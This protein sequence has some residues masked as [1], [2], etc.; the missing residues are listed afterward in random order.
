MSDEATIEGLQAELGRV[1]E[2]KRTAVEEAKTLRSSMADH[3]ANA[4]AAIAA[5]K[6]AEKALETATKR[7][8]GLDALGE[9]HAGFQ[10]RIADLESAAVRSAAQH[11]QHLTLADQHKLPAEA[12]EFFL[13]Q[14]GKTPEDGRPEFSAFM[15]AQ[16]ESTVYKA[17]RAPVV[18]VPAGVTPEVTSAAEVATT[19]S[20]VLDVTAPK[21]PGAVVPARGTG[22]VEGPAG[23]TPAHAGDAANA[24]GRDAIGFAAKYGIVVSNPERF[25]GV[26]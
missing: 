19:A 26:G 2:Q 20:P 18:E 23:G 22:R 9:Q 24:V 6:Q 16:S 1:R 3:Q 25:N 14:Y 13:H 15:E 4:T 11:A 7:L 10:A 5:Q 8:T 17:F 12:R 21:I